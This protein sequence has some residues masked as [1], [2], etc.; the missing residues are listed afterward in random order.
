MRRVVEGARRPGSKMLVPGRP[1]M[2]EERPMAAVALV[3][4]LRMEALLAMVAQLATVVGVSGAAVA[5]V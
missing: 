1:R 4:R 2:A 5:E 3:V